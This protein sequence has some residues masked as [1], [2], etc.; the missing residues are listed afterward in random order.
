MLF[1]LGTA[2]AH[3]AIYTYERSDFTIDR[4]FAGGDQSRAAY[5]SR[6]R[7]QP[8]VCPACQRT[9]AISDFPGD[10]SRLR[11]W[12][13]AWCRG[14]RVLVLGKEPSPRTIRRSPDYEDRSARA[15]ERGTVECHGC[16]LSVKVPGFA[17]MPTLEGREFRC[18]ACGIRTLVTPAV[19]PCT[20]CRRPTYAKDLGESGVCGAHG[21][22][23]FVPT[24][25]TAHE[26]GQLAE[27][28]SFHAKTAT[29]K[30]RRFLK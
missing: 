3:T 11:R 19:L 5:R 13:C 12:D 10:W 15:I 26:Q 6:A 9:T 21:E 25:A 4:D 29:H 17:G 23:V 18:S 22:T 14:E 20:F 2:A 27:V 28:L 16:G 30:L 7:N 24:L 8:V 1:E